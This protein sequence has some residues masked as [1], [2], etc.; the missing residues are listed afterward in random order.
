QT[1][2]VSSRNIRSGTGI[3]LVDI[4]ERRYSSANRFRGRSTGARYRRS[5]YPDYFQLECYEQSRR[6]YVDWRYSQSLFKGKTGGSRCS[7]KIR[8]TGRTSGRHS[9]AEWA[10]SNLIQD[11][12]EAEIPRRGLS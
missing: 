9:G 10:D 8:P 6:R 12:R 11:T 4:A 5:G 1:G 2:I 7:G 3:V